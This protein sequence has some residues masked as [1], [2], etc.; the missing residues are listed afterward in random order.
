ML[1]MIILTQCS[2]NQTSPPCEDSIWRK[3]IKFVYDY[4]LYSLGIRWVTKTKVIL[5]FIL[6]E[7]QIKSVQLSWKSFEYKL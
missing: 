6:Y 5:P 4:S 1:H 2:V 7:E 3:P